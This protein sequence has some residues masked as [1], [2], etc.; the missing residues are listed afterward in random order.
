MLTVPDGYT[1]KIEVIY[2][3]Y[4]ADATVADRVLHIA[5]V[6]RTVKDMTTLDATNVHFNMY[7][8]EAI[9]SGNAIQILAP[10]M[11]Y[12]PFA[13]VVA[14]MENEVLSIP[15]MKLYSGESVFVRYMNGAAGDLFRFSITYFEERL[16]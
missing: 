5:Y 10:S 9:S 15:E 16:V 1:W 4:V 13:G 12:K 2:C 8:N 14:G 6:D 7:A 11:S 3:D